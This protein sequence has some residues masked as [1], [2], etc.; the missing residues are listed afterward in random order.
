MMVTD[1][2]SPS[3]GRGMLMILLCLILISVWIPAIA[4]G[5]GSNREKSEVSKP[6]EVAGTL[7]ALDLISGRGIIRTDLG[8]PIYVEVRRPDLVRSLSV[9]DRVTIQ[10]NEDGQVDKIMGESVP[11]LVITGQPIPETTDK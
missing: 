11:E 6:Y 1:R 8:K 2:A 7:S 4:N 9:G 10:V 5:A 3:H